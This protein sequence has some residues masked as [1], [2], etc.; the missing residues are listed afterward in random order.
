MTIF[1][2]F[3]EKLGRIHQLFCRC[4]RNVNLGV[5]FI[6]NVFYIS[7]MEEP[8]LLTRRGVH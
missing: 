4:H 2:E 5:F 1:E 8:E 3:I 7:Y 6:L